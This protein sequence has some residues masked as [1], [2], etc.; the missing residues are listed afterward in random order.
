MSDTAAVRAV[1]F[2]DPSRKICL[3]LYYAMS[4]SRNLDELLRAP[5]GPVIRG[6]APRVAAP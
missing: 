6:R 4:V 1:F 5:L 2:I 3:V